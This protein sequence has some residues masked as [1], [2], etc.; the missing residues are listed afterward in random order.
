MGSTLIRVDDTTKIR[1]INLQNK[2]ES[3]D[4]TIQRMLRALEITAPEIHSVAINYTEK[5]ST[6]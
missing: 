1:L 6:Q 5:R 3:M 4:D 2:G